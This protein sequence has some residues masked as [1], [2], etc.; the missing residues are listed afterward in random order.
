MIFYINVHI[1]FKKI[2]NYTQQPKQKQLTKKMKMGSNTYLNLVSSIVLVVMFQWQCELTSA[3]PQTS[4]FTSRSI[5][6]RYPT[7][8]YSHVEG[9]PQLRSIYNQ[10]IQETST[11]TDQG[12]ATSRSVIN[13]IDHL[14]KESGD[15][16]S[17]TNSID[18]YISVYPERHAKRFFPKTGEIVERVLR[19]VSLRQPVDTFTSNGMET[20]R[21][22]HHKMFDRVV[23]N[24]KQDAGSIN[25]Y[26]H[27]G[28]CIPA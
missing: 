26:E 9:S 28:L 24:R 22:R 17:G 23:V 25:C 6:Q 14:M 16:S 12:D 2:S 19:F 4:S 11:A 5:N 10:Y 15:S 1:R 7:E 18:T 20:H 27:P 13:T 3:R 21:V 8:T